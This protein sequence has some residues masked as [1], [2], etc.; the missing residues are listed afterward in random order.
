[1]NKLINVEIF[2]LIPNEMNVQYSSLHSNKNIES[3]IYTYNTI[4]TDNTQI[5]KKDMK[6]SSLYKWQEIHLN[7]QNNSWVECSVSVGCLS[8]PLFTIDN[9]SDIEKNEEFNYHNQHFTKQEFVSMLSGE[10]GNVTHTGGVGSVGSVPLISFNVLDK[11]TR[12]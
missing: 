8:T 3:G 11:S 5:T 2:I 4:S 1:M 12:S 6:G 9:Y 10:C 7:L